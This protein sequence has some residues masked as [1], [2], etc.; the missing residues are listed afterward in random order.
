[1]VGRGFNATVIAFDPG[2]TG[3]EMRKIGV[4]KVEHLQDLCARAD[5]VSLHLPLNA[6]TKHMIG[7]SEFRGMKPKAIVVNTSRG[8][9]IDERA[10]FNALDRGLIAGAGLDVFEEEPVTSRN[11]LFSLDQVATSPHVG[12]SSEVAKANTSLAAARA[13]LDVLDGRAPQYFINK[14]ELRRTRA[15]LGV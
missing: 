6:R 7:E 9:I 1:M 8:G 10:L 2:I 14:N 11:P 3:D 15:R 12:G 5:I 13:M 4:E